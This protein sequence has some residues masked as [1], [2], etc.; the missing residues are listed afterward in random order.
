MM[1]R[2]QNITSEYKESEEAERLDS[3]SS[4]DSEY[5]PASEENT[6]EDND[7]GHEDSPSSSRG[8]AT[9]KISTSVMPRPSNARS[10]NPIQVV[11]HLNPP[12]HALSEVFSPQQLSQLGLQSLAQVDLLSNMVTPGKLGAMLLTFPKLNNKILNVEHLGRAMGIKNMPIPLP[13]SKTYSRLTPRETADACDELL[14]ASHPDFQRHQK[15]FHILHYYFLMRVLVVNSLSLPSPRLYDMFFCL[16]HSLPYPFHVTMFKAIQNRTK[17]FKA[18]RKG[19]AEKFHCYAAPIMEW[20]AQLILESD[21]PGSSQSP[22]TEK[23]KRPLSGRG[24]QTRGGHSKRTKIMHAVTYESMYEELLDTH[25][26]VYDRDVEKAALFD[27]NRIINRQVKD[28]K[29]VISSLNLQLCEAQEQLR[30]KSVVTTMV[31]ERCAQMELTVT[32]N[33]PV[34]PISLPTQGIPTT[35]SGGVPLASHTLTDQIHDD[36]W[37]TMYMEAKVLQNQGKVLYCQP[38]NPTASDPK[39]RPFILILQDEWM[40]EMGIRFSANNAWAIDSTFKTNKYGLPLFAAVLPNQL[41][42]GIPI[43]FMLCTCDVGA[44]HEVIALE[45]TIKRIFSRM[46]NVRLSALVIDK[47]QQELDALLRVVNEDPH[48]WEYTFNGTRRQIACHVLLCWFHTKKAWVEHLLPQVP[49]EMRKDVYS[50]MCNIMHSVTEEEFEDR[51][52]LLRQRYSSYGNIVRYVTNGWCG[53]DCMWR[54]CWPQFG[55]VFL[56]GNVDTI[57]LVERLWQYVKYTLLEA[58]INR[59]LLELIH[60]LVGNSKTGGRMGGTLL[61][62]FKQNQEIAD[63]GRYGVPGNS[64]EH[65]ARLLAGER[66]LQRYEENQDTLQVL[67]AMQ[68]Q[69]RILSMTTP[70]QWYQVN[71]QSNY[72]DCSDWSSECK[73]LYGVKLIVKHHFPEITMILSVLD[74]AHQTLATYDNEIVTEEKEEKVKTCI[75]ELKE[76]LLSLEQE[77]PNKSPKDMEIML[78]QLRLSKDMLGALLSPSQIDMPACGSVRQIKAHVTRTR[79][80]HGVP[81]DVGAPPLEAAPKPIPHTGSL[82]RKHQRG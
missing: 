82:K 50:T 47:S 25:Q 54:V 65:R 12:K 69:F 43:W 70:N 51:F 46:A 29:E 44:R 55:R 66:I 59:S 6:S 74:N 34:A 3:E 33:T 57:N 8:T 80:G 26:R 72:C 79:L 30:Q 31:C 27:R 22:A 42:V 2:H 24:V 11:F 37:A 63:S 21:T 52:Q 28:L 67:N 23:G 35:N 64:K 61:R 58:R 40:L 13:A 5:A 36:D 75:H 17:R 10:D 56:H 60:A 4:D 16:C 48:C 45:I 73:H 9:D 68:L 7:Q 14:S 76:L 78:H 81:K 38:Y 62:F 32:T 20:M 1:T 41:G 18:Q 15:I 19:K 53:R 77:I 49:K 71:F 39:D